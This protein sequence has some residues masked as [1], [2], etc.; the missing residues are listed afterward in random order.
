MSNLNKMDTGVI[1]SAHCD[2]AILSLGGLIL[3]GGS[4]SIVNIFSN[5][6]W[7]LQKNLV[8]PKEI[9]RLNKKEERKAISKTKS[10]LEMLDL[11]EALLRGY[12]EW[13][14][15]LIKSSQEQKLRKRVSQILVQ[16]IS[17]HKHAYVPL[18]VGEH[19]DHKIIFQETIKLIKKNKNNWKE[20]II[21]FYE[22]LPY[23]TDYPVKKQI[24]KLKMHSLHVVPKLINITDQMQRKLELLSYYKTQLDEKELEKV[25]NHTVDP[26]SKGTCYERVWKL[27]LKT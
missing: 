14:A 22:D 5:C 9:T 15:S 21:Y 2:D 19:V 1:L 13:N 17:T 23:A 20:K 12:K 6:A 8:D 27:Y 10:D 26:G 11:P 18:A 25:R 24:T 16:K 7:S 4:F 3:K